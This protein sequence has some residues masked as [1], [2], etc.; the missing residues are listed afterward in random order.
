M[1]ELSSTISRYPRSAE[2]VLKWYC[3]TGGFKPAVFHGEECHVRMSVIL[4]MHLKS[5]LTSLL[6]NLPLR[7]KMIDKWVRF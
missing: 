4:P 2:L 6:F 7:G 1:I 5:Y 3:G